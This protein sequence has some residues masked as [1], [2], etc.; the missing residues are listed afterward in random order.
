LRA[1]S[2]SRLHAR[3]QWRQNAATIEDMS[4][5]HLIITLLVSKELKVTRDCNGYFQVTSADKGTA[6]RMNF[7]HV[8]VR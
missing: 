6:C 4:P 3:Q 2:S 7:G 8:Y 5:S 1:A